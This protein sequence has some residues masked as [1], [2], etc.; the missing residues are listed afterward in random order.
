MTYADKPDDEVDN[1]KLSRVDNFR[2]IRIHQRL[3]VAEETSPRRFDY[4]H[5][6]DHDGE[7]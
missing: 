6:Y 4:H 3:V 7:N 5:E 1:D 2:F